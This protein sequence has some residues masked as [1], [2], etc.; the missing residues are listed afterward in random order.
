MADFQQAAIQ[1]DS[2]DEKAFEDMAES[3]GVTVS[4]AK[5][6]IAT[7]A[8]LSIAQGD[9]LVQRARQARVRVFN[10]EARRRSHR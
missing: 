9:R 5:V 3:A 7:L 6:V 4:Q 1:L 2:E 8:T 10:A